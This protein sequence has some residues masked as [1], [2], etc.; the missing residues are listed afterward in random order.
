MKR[1]TKNMSISN[2]C[3]SICE[4]EAYIE[5]LEDIINKKVK[6]HLISKDEAENLLPKA[7]RRLSKLKAMLYA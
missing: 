1:I 6:I 7:K 4:M 5:H 3:D 2:I